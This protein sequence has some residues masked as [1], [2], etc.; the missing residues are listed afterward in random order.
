MRPARS[1]TGISCSPE[2]SFGLAA[3]FPAFPNPFVPEPIVPKRSVRSSISRT[4]GRSVTFGMLQRCPRAR[5]IDKV[6]RYWWWC[7]DCR[8]EASRA[9]R[10]KH[11]DECNDR[12]RV[13]P[14]KLRCIE[15]SEEFE[16]RRGRLL[17]SRRCKDRRYARSIRRSCGRS[18]DGGMRAAKQHDFS[19]GESPGEPQTETQPRLG[20][21]KVGPL[22]QVEWSSGASLTLTPASVATRLRFAPDA[23]PRQRAMLQAHQA[24]AQ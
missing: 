18:S 8:R 14:S 21:P 11:R 23:P 1:A 7:L 13:P 9:W 24:G 19:R 3:W 12:R 4:S 5:R 6:Q 16:G 17:C 10:A 2:P 15:C 20:T 22:H